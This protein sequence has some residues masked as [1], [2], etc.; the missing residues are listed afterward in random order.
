[1]E[2]SSKPPEFAS[3]A[4]LRFIGSE[5]LSDAV[6][7]VL[8]KPELCREFAR[9]SFYLYLRTENPVPVNS[10]VS[11]VDRILNGHDPLEAY[12]AG[13][14]QSHKG[15]DLYTSHFP[16]SSRVI[17]G[18]EYSG[19]TRGVS[20]LF[21]LAIGEYEKQ[22]LLAPPF[23]D[24]MAGAAYVTADIDEDWLVKGQDRKQD[25]ADLRAA[26]GANYRSYQRRGYLSDDYYVTHPTA[27]I[28]PAR[29]PSRHAQ[30]TH[31][32]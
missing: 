22:R 31:K 7:N 28:I 13:I 10:K 16:L 23:D 6:E 15:Q 26:M 4:T 20:L 27:V 19:A 9:R 2:D 8:I 11:N 21:R 5:S 29:Y 32:S 30:D 3:R 25:F 12:N 18:A 17:G 24:V 1:M 14:A